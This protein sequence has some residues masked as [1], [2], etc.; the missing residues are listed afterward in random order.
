MHSGALTMLYHPQQTH[1]LECLV[2]LHHIIQKDLIV[3]NDGD[4]RTTAFSRI[5]LAGVAN[6]MRASEARSAG[7]KLTEPFMK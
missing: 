3:G 7:G 6:K 2:S 1:Y 5:L 4:W